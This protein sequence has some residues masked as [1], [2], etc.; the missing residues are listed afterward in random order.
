[1]TKFIQPHCLVLHSELC[2]HRVRT[3]CCSSI[4]LASLSQAEAAR[5]GLQ[6]NNVASW[7]KQEAHFLP[8]LNQTQTVQSSSVQ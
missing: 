6:S 1:M 7:V 4:S 3:L 8:V 2:G 5:T